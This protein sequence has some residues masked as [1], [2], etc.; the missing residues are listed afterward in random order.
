MAR[1]ACT[2]PFADG[3]TRALAPPGSVP[4]D[5]VAQWLAMVEPG[6]V[7]AKFRRFAA[8]DQVGTEAQHFVAVEDWANDGIALSN[9]AAFEI[10][11]AW[12]ARNLPME[13]GF[14]VEGEP[15]RPEAVTIP[16]MVVQATRDRLVPA[17]SVR[18]LAARLGNA[19]LLDVQTGHIGM[20]V[21]RTAETA[22]IE[23]AAG[24][25]S[26]HLPPARTR[27]PKRR[28]S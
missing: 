17:A 5:L 19:H 8:M 11:Q 27:R 24:W 20:F 21:G 13:G 25:L 7:Q 22:M 1:L 3:L 6:G 26:T 15:V 18:P 9:P 23:P 28:K 2:A 10:F 4:A 12:P 14:I 16:A